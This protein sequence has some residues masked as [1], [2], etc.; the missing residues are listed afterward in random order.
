MAITINVEDEGE[1]H[2]SLLRPD[3]QVMGQQAVQAFPKLIFSEA[4]LLPQPGK[5]FNEIYC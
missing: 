1:G 3:H 4:K 2:G 5:S